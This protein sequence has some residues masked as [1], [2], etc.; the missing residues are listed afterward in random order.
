MSICQAKKTR[1]V[2]SMDESI[3]KKSGITSGV[4]EWLDM[5]RTVRDTSIDRGGV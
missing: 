3:I 5:K 2:F 1:R 4:C